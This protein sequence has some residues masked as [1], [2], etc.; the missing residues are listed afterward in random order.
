MTPGERVWVVHEIESGDVP[1][2]MTLIGARSSLREVDRLVLKRW[3][4]FSR[5]EADPGEFS[6]RGGRYVE[7]QNPGVFGHIR[8]DLVVVDDP[9]AEG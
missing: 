5:Y 9:A 2:S 3:P 8:V 6:G 1:G 7:A 4:K